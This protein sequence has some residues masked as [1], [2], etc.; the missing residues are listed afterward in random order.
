MNK[1][2]SRR[3]IFQ[4]IGLAAASILIVFLVILYFAKTLP[5][6]EQISAQQISQSTKDL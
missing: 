5:S 2:T 3:K 6:I 4:I 1:E